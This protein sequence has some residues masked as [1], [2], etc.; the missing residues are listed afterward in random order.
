MQFVKDSLEIHELVRNMFEWSD[1]A[2]TV[3]DFEPDENALKNGH[4]SDLDEKF[5]RRVMRSMRRSGFFTKA[6]IRNYDSVWHTVRTHT[7][8][9]YHPWPVDDTPPWGLYRPW[10]DCM[11]SIPNFWYYVYTVEMKIIDNKRAY[12]FWTWGDDNYSRAR[13]E[14]SW[15]KWKISYLNGLDI[16]HYKKPKD[17]IATPLHLEEYDIRTMTPHELDSIIGF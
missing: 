4:Y 5:H 9:G 15:G 17:E 6:F 2:V 12:F 10:C 1:E 13:A 16:R 3:T 7:R 8:L 11:E 14:K